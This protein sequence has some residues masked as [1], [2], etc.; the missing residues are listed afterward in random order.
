MFIT[1][2]TSLEKVPLTSKNNVTHD[3][4]TYDY[5]GWGLYTDEGSTDVE[6]NYNLVYH[7]KSGAFHQHYGKN[8]K[9][10]NNILALAYTNLLQCTR[11]ENHLSFTFKHNLM[12]TDEE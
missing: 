6:M 5:G 9:I 8:N 3:V 7:Y 11:A 4:Y 12:L 2:R 10:T 1:N